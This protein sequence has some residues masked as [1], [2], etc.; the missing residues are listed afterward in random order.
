VNSGNAPADTL[1][2]AV[3][4]HYR[5][6]RKL[7]EGGMGQVYEAQDLQL[8]RHV[9]LKVLPIELSKRKNAI[10]RFRRE[11]C[12]TSALN[13]PNIC[14]IHEI[15]EHDGRQFIVSELLCGQTLKQVID[16]QPTDKAVLEFSLQISDALAAAHSKGVVHRDIKPANIFL[17]NEQRIKLLDFGVATIACEKVF[18]SPD[19][20]TAEEFTLSQ[21]VEVSGTIPY[22]SPEQLRAQSTGPA[23]DIFSLG[24]VLWEMLSRTHPFEKGNTL[25]TASAILCQPLPNWSTLPRPIPVQWREILTRMLAKDAAQRY[26]NAQELQRDLLH[27]KGSIV[28]RQ[29]GG[30]EQ[31]RKQTASIAVLPFVNTSGSS[32][33]DYVSDGVAEEII[34]ALTDIRGLRVAARSSSFRFRAKELDICKVGRQLHVESI[35]E[36]SMRKFGNRLR[37]LAQLINVADGLHLWSGKFDR[38]MTDILTIQDEIARAVVDGLELVF[39]GESSGMMRRRTS[40]V[41]A[42]NVYLKGRYFWN[43]RTAEDLSKAVD[44]F[45]QAIALDSKFGSALAGLADCYV[46]LAIYGAQAP[47]AVIPLAK[48]AAQQALMIDPGSPEAYTSLACAYAIYDW[49][50]NTA[51]RTFRKAIQADPRYSVAHHWYASNLLLPSG[52]F[53]EARWHL[54]L[55]SQLDPLSLPILTTIGLQHLFE[56]NYELAIEQFNRV[57]EMD[58]NFGIARFFIGQAYAEKNMHSEAVAELEQAVALTGQSAEAV[59]SLGR[60]LASAGEDSRAEQLLTELRQLSRQTYVSP[61]LFAEVQLGLKQIDAAL[62]LLEEAQHSHAADLFWIG[63][64]PWFDPLRGNPRFDAICDHVFGIG[65]RPSRVA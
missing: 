21:D 31:A 32:E 4:R 43:R 6:V 16:H 12:I 24:I 5:I 8:Y 18:G 20:M 36:G 35:L 48:E 27:L 50:W 40:D 15:G 55:A 49:D 46:V 58:P 59:A 28:E 52:R 63:V 7:G 11:A 38:E 2:N 54:G 14:T 56:R 19:D 64:R 47:Q 10:E 26:G 53:S 51:E 61:V 57:L 42:H 39:T 65:T 22:M 1:I 23:S 37:I 44:C 41:E 60:V 34:S 30:T 45:K 33:N 25:E 13:H 9:A 17:T 3:L 62:Q 29:L